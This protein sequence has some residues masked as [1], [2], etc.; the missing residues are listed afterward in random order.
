MAAEMLWN[1][2]CSWSF[3]RSPHRHSEPT[4]PPKAPKTTRIWTLRVV[5]KDHLFGGRLVE[6]V[7]SPEKLKIEWLQTRRYLSAQDCIRWNSECFGQGFQEPCK[8]AFPCK[9]YA[10]WFNA[11]F[12]PQL[13]SL[14]RIQNQQVKYQNWS[15][16]EN[17]L[18]LSLYGRGL[19]RTCTLKHPVFV[20]YKK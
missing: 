3:G 7:V 20:C 5:C 19:A 15:Q 6:M 13:W 2:K 11:R 1:W 12:C 9:I 17:S 4:G 10:V 16:V 8:K 18:V 14:C